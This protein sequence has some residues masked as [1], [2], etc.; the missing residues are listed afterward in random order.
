MRM[1]LEPLLYHYR[2][3]F[4]FLL[5]FDLDSQTS[6]NNKTGTTRPIRRDGVGLFTIL[7]IIIISSTTH[8]LTLPPAKPAT[9]ITKH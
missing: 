1:R 8:L 2:I 3:F 4:F 5:L 7:P 9:V 6:S